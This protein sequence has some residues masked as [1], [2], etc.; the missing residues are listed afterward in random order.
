MINWAAKGVERIVQNAL[1]LTKLTQ[2][3]IPQD[4]GRG[5]VTAVF[6]K[7]VSSEEFAISEVHRVVNLY[8]PRAIVES[9]KFVDGELL[10][11]VSADE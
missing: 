3:E 11:E 7:G 2:F 5:I 10:M 4:L 6:D 9:A 1:N 8:E